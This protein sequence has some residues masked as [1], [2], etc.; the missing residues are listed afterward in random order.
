[1][2]TEV[3]KVIDIQTKGAESGVKSLKQQIKELREAMAQME[4][5]SEEW[6]A[7]STQLADTLQKQTEITEAAKFANKDYGATMQNVGTAMAGVTAGI[8]AVTSG[9]SLMGIEVDNSDIG[10]IKF[11]QNLMAITQALTVMDSASKAWKGLLTAFNAAL[12]QKIAD[13][14]ATAANTAATEANTAASAEN[15]AAKKAQA[16][17][18]GE[19]AAAMATETAATGTATTKTGGLIGVFSKLVTIVKNAKLAFGIAGVALTALTIIFTNFIKNINEAHKK[20]KEYNDLQKELKT[21]SVEATATI[22]EQ[23]DILHDSNATYEQRLTALNELKNAFPEYKAQLTTE[24]EL[25]NDNNEYIRANIQLMEQKA[26]A[27]ALESRYVEQLK[28]EKELEEEINNIRKGTDLSW[29]QKFMFSDFSGDGI[30][31]DPITQW[32]LGKTNDMRIKDRQEELEKLRESLKLTKEE[33]GKLQNTMGT[34]TTAATW[35]NQNTQILQFKA[36]VE[37]TKRSLAELYSTFQSNLDEFSSSGTRPV[38]KKFVDDVNAVLAGAGLSAGK[39]FGDG[40]WEG[41][42][43]ALDRAPD[44]EFERGIFDIAGWVNESVA[45]ADGDIN[46]FFN[47][48]E[49]RLT[50]VEGYLDRGEELMNNYIGSFSNLQTVWDFPRINKNNFFNPEFIKSLQTQLTSLRQQYAAIGG[51][52]STMTESQAEQNMQIVNNW[53]QNFAQT[54][55]DLQTYQNAVENA[56]KKL[57]DAQN[58]YNRRK[59][60]ILNKN[61]ST[62]EREIELQ[63]LQYSLFNTQIS[64]YRTELTNATTALN[65]YKENNSAVLQGLDEQHQSFIDATDALNKYNLQMAIASDNSTKLG[66]KKEEIAG[67]ISA[68]E[69]IMELFSGLQ[70]TQRNMLK[71][72]YD[73]VRTIIPGMVERVELEREYQ[74]ARK[75]GNL[76]ADYNKTKATLELEKSEIEERINLYQRVLTEWENGAQIEY[77]VV[78]DAAKQLPQLMEQLANKETDIL[79]NEYQ[80]RT[81]L[82]NRWIENSKL[83][84]DSAYTDLETIMLEHQNIWNLGAE[85]YNYQMEQLEAQRYFLEQRMNDLESWREQDLINEADYLEQRKQLN[86]EYANLEV[87]IEREKTNRQ[88]KIH[89][90]YYNGLKSITST[91]TSLMGALADQYEQDSEEYRDIMTLQTWITGFAGSLD[92]FVSGVKS[93]IPAPY[94]FILAGVLSAATLTETALTVA[95][96]KSASKTSGGSTTSA[97]NSVNTPVYETLAY[98]TNSEING[99]ISDQRVYVVESDITDSIN[100]VQVVEDEASF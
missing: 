25:L 18:S 14:T 27:Q 34:I 41:L 32:M 5:G 48:I 36:S 28:Q 81:E 33:F 52:V 73:L 20:Q 11:T 76:D 58:E 51:T 50:D 74:E 37:S 94:N 56:N 91:I 79:N 8:T 1:M 83:A 85:D 45:E 70:T 12:D 19:N 9:L 80:H 78:A 47:L 66:I 90:T 3:K 72:G 69:K 2:A 35:K 89:E 59:T 93:G 49:Q 24:G 6:T 13:T 17:A 96:I 43:D 46:Q 15:A 57:F 71:E 55:A 82:L 86:Q 92:A 31:T 97:A 67:Q 26:Q 62:E 65:Q 63:Q 77:S 39:I 42:T 16:T 75:K 100:T 30:M 98:E 54:W 7:A 44:T 61:I 29:F 95:K 23:N 38:F 21:A 60:E 87:D 64:V 4:Q 10:M 68:I 88:L 40:V 22:T 84:Y 99:N 53:N